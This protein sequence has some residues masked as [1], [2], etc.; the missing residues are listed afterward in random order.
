[1]WWQQLHTV[2]STIEVVVKDFKDFVKDNHLIYAA[3]LLNLAFIL[4]V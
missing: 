3:H 4:K 1:M 2:I